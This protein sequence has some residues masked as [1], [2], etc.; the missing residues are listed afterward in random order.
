MAVM[1]YYFL[2]L[3]FNSSLCQFF[4]GIYL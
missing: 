2:I 4:V 3:S 1:H